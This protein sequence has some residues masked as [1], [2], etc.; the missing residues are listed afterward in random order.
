LLAVAVRSSRATNDQGK[1]TV[2][3]SRALASLFST[4]TVSVGVCGQT[5]SSNNVVKIII[6]MNPC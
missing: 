6:A 5:N 1:A 2:S 4:L 3:L